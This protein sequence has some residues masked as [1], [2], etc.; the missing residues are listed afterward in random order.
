MLMPQPKPPEEEEGLLKL[1]IL[2][3]SPIDNNGSQGSWSRPL[4]VES[5]E[6]MN[7]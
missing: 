4:T 7:S 3:Y 5:R 2:G 1:T 6:R